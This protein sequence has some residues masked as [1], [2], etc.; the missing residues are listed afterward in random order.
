MLSIDM[1]K[2]FACAVKKLLPQADLVHDRF[3]ISK[4]FNTAVDIVR[5]QESRQLCK[6]GDT[7]LIGSK[8]TWLGNPENLNPVQKGRFDGLLESMLESGVAWV[9]KHSFRVF[10]ECPTEARAKLFFLVLV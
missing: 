2:P 5:R 1:W 9:L 4:Y 3:H 8:F 6:T 10:W 7:S